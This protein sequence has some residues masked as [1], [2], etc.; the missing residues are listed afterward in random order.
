MGV[1][2]QTWGAA[3][4]GIF[5]DFPGHA[6]NCRH[7]SRLKRLEYDAQS[8]GRDPLDLR[9][10]DTAQTHKEG[11][12]A[13]RARVSQCLVIA[14][15]LLFSEPRQGALGPLCPPK[16]KLRTFSRKGGGGHRGGRP[17]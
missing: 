8:R 14:P 16:T 7:R 11:G 6:D 3:K 13:C 4:I 12:E 17:V 5:Y 15:T 9:L 10:T 1:E 2:N